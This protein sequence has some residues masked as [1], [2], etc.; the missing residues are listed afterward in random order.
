[1]VTD[2]YIELLTKLTKDCDISQH[3]VDIITNSI[4]KRNVK[5]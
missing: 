1:M 5:N 2:G 3:A 4:F